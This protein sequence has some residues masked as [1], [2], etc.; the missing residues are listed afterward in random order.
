MILLIILVPRTG[1]ICDSPRFYTDKFK[2]FTGSPYR[3]GRRT[4]KKNHKQHLS[5]HCGG[6]L[7]HYAGPKRIPG[8]LQKLSCVVPGNYFLRAKNQCAYT[9]IEYTLVIDS[10]TIKNQNKK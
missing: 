7:A 5:L 3:K 10:L 2:S 8:I 1:E 6:F 9:G 4:N